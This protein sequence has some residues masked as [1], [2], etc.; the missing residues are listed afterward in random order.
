MEDGPRRDS[1]PRIWEIPQPRST[2]TVRLDDGSVTTVRRH[3]NPTGP[4]LV[5]SHGTGLAI[6]LYVPFWSALLDHFD[7]FIH[8]IRNHGWNAVGALANHTIPTFARDHAQ[9]V[10]AID[11]RCGAKPKIGIYHSLAAMAALV[12]LT[13]TSRQKPVL[14]ALVLYDPPL[15]MRGVTDD[16]FFGLAEVAAVKT[17]RKRSRFAT[18]ADFEARVAGAS[19]FGHVVP[20]VYDLMARTML[21][22]RADGGYELRCPPEYEARVFADARRWP[23]RVDFA[24]IGCPVK[25]IASDPSN[26]A[27]YVPSL[28]DR[29]LAVVEYET[30]PGT[31]HFLPLE[32]PAA[33][34]RAML[35]YLRG[36]RLLGDVGVDAGA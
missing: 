3:G 24:G 28:D 33:C 17:R 4:C 23:A 16:V 9:I 20:G 21:R 26:P 6:D 5:L 30:I 18:Q 13:R 25:V 2:F 7:V 1:G 10:A 36:H 35:A 11:G 12:S 22:E 14:D 19:R 8:D 32:A 34:V 27:A 15:Y 29:Q 31:T